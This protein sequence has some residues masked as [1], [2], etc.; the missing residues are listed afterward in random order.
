ML[1]VEPGDRVFVETGPQSDLTEAAVGPWSEFA[2]AAHVPQVAV[3]GEVPRARVAGAEE[4]VVPG[5]G[6]KGGLPYLGI[7]DGGGHPGDVPAERGL[8]RGLAVAEQ[9]VGRAE[10][11]VEVLVVRHV[12]GRR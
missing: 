6:G 5:D 2:A 4:G 11:R 8:E 1:L 12:V 7:A 3:G 9:V 10:P